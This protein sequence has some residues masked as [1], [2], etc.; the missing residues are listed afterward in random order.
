MTRGL[1]IRILPLAKSYDCTGGGTF[2]GLGGKRRSP[3]TSES[4]LQEMS[5]ARCSIQGVI[6][7]N[8]DAPRRKSSRAE[9]GGKTS[10]KRFKKSSGKMIQGAH[11]EN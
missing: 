3:R 2:K 10:R 7:E 11:L 9:G 1:E 8:E 4:V 6:R 5:L